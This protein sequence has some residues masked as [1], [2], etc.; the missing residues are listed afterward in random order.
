MHTMSG[1]SSALRL[2]PLN[3]RHWSSR[4]SSCKAAALDRAPSNHKPEA[5]AKEDFM[6]HSP[7]LALQACDA[8]GPARRP[9]NSWLASAIDLALILVWAARPSF[10]DTTPDKHALTIPADFVLKG[11]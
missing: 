10:G 2:R 1:S 11:G 7:S 8:E 6:L 3:G 5:Q 4:F 9:R